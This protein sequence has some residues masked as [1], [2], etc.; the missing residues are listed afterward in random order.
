MARFFASVFIPAGIW[1]GFFLCLMEA[2]ALLLDLL[3]M[4]VV[5]PPA[6][7]HTSAI[8]RR[9]GKSEPDALVVIQ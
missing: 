8:K 6:E 3:A 4:F 9:I 5:E 7:F 2:T 1:R